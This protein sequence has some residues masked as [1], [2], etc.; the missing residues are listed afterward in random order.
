LAFQKGAIVIRIDQPAGL[1]NAAEI[2]RSIGEAA[3]EWR[4]DTDALSWSD[5]AGAVLGADPGELASGRA[6][7]QRVVAEAGQARIDAVQQSTVTDTGDG[8]A[9]Q[10]QYAF[11]RGDEILQ[12]EDSGRWFAGADGKPQRAHGVVRRIDERYARELRLAQLAK[13]DPLTGELNRAYL[14]DVL[15][16]TVEDAIR[17]RGS[18]GF[19]LVAIDHLGRLNE[20]YGFDVAEE[21]IAKVANRL[22]ARLRGKDHLGRFSGNKFG[23]ILTQC[24]PDEIAVAR[25]PPPRRRPAAPTSPRRSGVASPPRFN[26]RCTD[27]ANVP[28]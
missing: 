18:T 7:A 14:T 4:L 13:Y 9:Y 19:L 26:L 5:N 17:F 28:P 11:R 10:V 12:I 25:P 20:A 2:L 6:Y 23:V 1:P 8:V 21:I 16:A 3:Y 27:P 15:T 22:R 24:T